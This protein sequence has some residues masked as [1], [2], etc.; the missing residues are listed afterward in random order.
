[1]RGFPERPRSFV[2]PPRYGKAPRYGAINAGAINIAAAGAV[3]RELGGDIY[4]F[5]CFWLFL[6]V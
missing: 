5:S 6:V 2:R 4:V 3:D 1:M